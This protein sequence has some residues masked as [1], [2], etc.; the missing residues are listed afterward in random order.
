[1][2]SKPPAPSVKGQLL[3]VRRR[4][5]EISRD[6]IDKARR[7][8]LIASTVGFF[9]WATEAVPNNIA[10]L[11]VQFSAVNKFWFSLILAGIVLYLL[12]PFVAARLDWNKKVAILDNEVRTWK[13]DQMILGC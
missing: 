2:T 4:R 6:A 12:V 11:G 8:S 13:K 7:N 9:V 3:D 1:M 10:A 5:S